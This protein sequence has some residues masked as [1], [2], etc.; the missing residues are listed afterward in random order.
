MVT[1]ITFIWNVTQCLQKAAITPYIE[2]AKCNPHP[3]PYFSN[4]FW[5]FPPNYAQVSKAMFNIQA[6]RPQFCTDLHLPMRDTCS[7]TLI[8]LDLIVLINFGVEFKLRSSF[9]CRLFRTVLLICFIFYYAGSRYVKLICY[10]KYFISTFLD[11]RLMKIS[12]PGVMVPTNCVIFQRISGCG[13]VSQFN[14]HP[15]RA[16]T[17]TTVLNLTLVLA[18][19]THRPL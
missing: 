6:F 3:A 10:G 11:A 14:P 16:R 13:E 7:I 9:I 2:L 18:D 15:V 12:N 4:L 19:I 8:F 17:H 1:W 5:Y